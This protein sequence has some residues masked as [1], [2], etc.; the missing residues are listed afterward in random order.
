MKTSE[1]TVT[2]RG[3]GLKEALLQTEKLGADCGLDSKQI[4]RLR[5]LAE[6]L[7][8]MSKSIVGELKGR[9][10]VEESE[11]CFEIQLHSDVEMTKE[12]KKQLISVSSAGKNSASKGFMGKLKD[13]IATALLP[14]ED[15]ISLTSGFSLGLVGI[16]SNSGPAA[17]AAAA[18]A[19][20]WSMNR[21]KNAIESKQES[22]AEAKEAYD[23]LEKSIIANIADEITVCIK[24]STVEISIK[25]QF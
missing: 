11:R 24:G 12:M 13:M 7:F 2:N 17:Q 9:Y 1:I 25:K 3:E 8:G 21:Y 16:A 18:D 20:Y 15:G 19:Y 10:C 22:D 5:L 14:N 6:E 23:E 4:L